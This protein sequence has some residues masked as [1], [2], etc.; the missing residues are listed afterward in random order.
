MI[1]SESCITE[2]S[3]NNETAQ[4][5]A[6]SQKSEAEELGSSVNQLLNNLLIAGAKLEIDPVQ[7][8]YLGAMHAWDR[9]V[10]DTM[11][12]VQCSFDEETVRGIVRYVDRYA[13]RDEGYTDSRVS[14]LLKWGVEQ[15]LM[16]LAG[17]SFHNE[18]SQYRLTQL[19]H[20]LLKP[21]FKDEDFDQQESLSQRYKRIEVL[22]GELNT[23][24]AEDPN[25]W[26]ESVRSYLPTLKHVVNMVKLLLQ[27]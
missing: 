13:G 8:L 3:A 17:T 2:V 24:E 11:N 19:A 6:V 4:E 20:D 7:Y 16:T 10:D 1:A 27:S 12:L 9:D 5:A 14:S 25:E 21:Y 23:I 26:F 22:L 15:R 18:D